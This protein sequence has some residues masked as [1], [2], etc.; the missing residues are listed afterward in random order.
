MLWRSR[1]RTALTLLSIVIAFFLF[2]LLQSVLSLFEADVRLANAENLYVSARSGAGQPLPIAY[3]H[4]MESVP[5]VTFVTP[6]VPLDAWYQD[7]KNGLNTAVIDPKWLAVDPRFV[8]PADQVKTI[9]RTR[10]AIVVGR[11]LAQKYGWKLGDRVPIQSSTPKADGSATWEFEVAGIFDFNKQLMGNV[12]SL[13]VFVNYDYFDEARLFDKGQVMLYVVRIGNPAQTDAVTAAVDRL[14]QNSA[15]ETKT[16]TESMFNLDQAN[17]F[18]DVGLI[19][20]GI[21][22]AVFFTLALVAGNTM[23][24]AFRERVPQ[25]AVLKTIGFGDG[26]VAGLIAVEALMLTVGGG[27]A[28]LGLAFALVPATFK[29]VIPASPVINLDGATAL[30][31]VGAAVLLGLAAALIP[32]WKARRLTIVAALAGE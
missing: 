31:G 12:P 18:A 5:G 30:A 8:L 17:Q 7:R 28:G 16:Q 14:F 21:L 4:D 23:A 22:T 13:N 29:A 19:V 2:G 11:D 1:T 25:L 26:S 9:E 15:A 24:Q 6:V 27:V 20:H 32:A 3:R 10:T